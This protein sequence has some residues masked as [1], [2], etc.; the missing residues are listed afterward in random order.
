M[1]E[2][3]AKAAFRAMGIPRPSR[4]LID[5]WL[6]AEELKE[7]WAQIEEPVKA[8][9]APATPATMEASVP[10]AASTSP[11]LRGKS[12]LEPILRERGDLP[13]PLKRR[14]PGRPRIVA[15]WFPAVAKTMADGTTL[16]TALA[17]NGLSLCANE[18][19]ALY[20]NR[21]LQALYQEARRRY[22]IENWGRARGPSLRSVLGRRL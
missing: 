12:L 20:R 4:S 8:E 5:A 3:D 16:R 19:R 7:Q 18:M 13:Q 14:K 17:I 10:Q 22:L 15:S 6:R 2:S 21:T 9:T 11:A 1:N